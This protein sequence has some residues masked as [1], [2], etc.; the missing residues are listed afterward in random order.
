M[1]NEP[2]WSPTPEAIENSQLTAWARWLKQQGIGPDSEQYDDLW[3]W[4]TEEPEQFWQ[5]IWDYFDVLHDGEP[6]AVL[7]SHEMPGAKWFEGTRF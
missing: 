7:S 2:L 5:S 4:S 1:S 3:A 6:K